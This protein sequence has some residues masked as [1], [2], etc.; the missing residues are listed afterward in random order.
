MFERVL[1]RLLS[2]FLFFS[3]KLR[4]IKENG[5]GFAGES[6]LLSITIRKW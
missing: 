3:L 2:R 1:S 4:G 6:L 5:K